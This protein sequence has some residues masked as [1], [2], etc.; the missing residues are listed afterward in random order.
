M[1]PILADSKLTWAAE[2]LVG[3]KGWGWG[4]VWAIGREEVRL[5]R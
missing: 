5:L 3:G 2:A 4:V 1:S